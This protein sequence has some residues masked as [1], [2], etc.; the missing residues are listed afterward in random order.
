[1]T[2]RFGWRAWAPIAAALLL[3][4]AAPAVW[5]QADTVFLT[6]DTTLDNALQDAE[7]LSLADPAGFLLSISLQYKVP[8][9]DLQA[10]KDQGLKP[11]EILLAVNLLQA[12]QKTLA[13]VSA[14]WKANK[15]K[16]WGVIAKD[17]GVKPGSDAFQTLKKNT[18]A[19][20]DRL[21]D[22]EDKKPAGA[23]MMKAADPNKAP[24]DM[25]AKKPDAAKKP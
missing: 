12:T 14:S 7:D 5:A 23:M 8:L 4:V 20:K 3:T 18:L 10:L 2:F 19:E 22:E 13:Q 15:G 6:G 21:K 11:G 24:G 1:M 9:K 25:K 16:G 17:L